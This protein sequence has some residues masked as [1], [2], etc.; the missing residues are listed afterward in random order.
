M[1]LNLGAGT[2][3]IDGYIG[4]DIS[5]QADVTHDL[6]LPLPFD[7]ES[8]EE[9]LAIHL[10]ES[11]YEW[12]FPLVLKDWYRVMGKGAKL[13]IEFTVLSET[14]KF[15]LSD[16]PIIKQRGHWGLYGNQSQ[17]VDPIVLH[18]YVYEK[19]ELENKLKDAGF[20][21]ITFD[22]ESIDHCKIRDLRIVCYK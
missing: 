22:S 14:I 8:I 4:V 15:Y 10:I 16:D 17:P 18:H 2:Q 5:G 11:F 13:T 9:I 1:R 3:K 12:E 21:D 7:D 20:R 6:R 19:D